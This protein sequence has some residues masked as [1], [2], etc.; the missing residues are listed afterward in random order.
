[1]S[2]AFDSIKKGIEEAIQYEK[3][4]TRGVRVYKPEPINAKEIRLSIGMTQ[5]EF[6]ASL[7]IS[8]GTLRH[9]ERGDRTPSGPALVLLNI[10]AKQPQL[11]LQSLSR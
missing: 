2:E 5:V 4:N 11:V 7:G 3:G 8:L 10:T 1:M 6:S 9:W